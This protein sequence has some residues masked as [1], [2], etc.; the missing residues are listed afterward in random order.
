MT[1]PS[2]REFLQFWTFSPPLPAPTSAIRNSEQYPPHWPICHCVMSHFRLP[3]EQHTPF[4]GPVRD[5]GYGR[6]RGALT[7][8]QKIVSSRKFLGLTQEQ[9]A[10]KADIDV[11]TIRNA[12]SGKRLDLSTIQ[13]VAQC[14]LIPWQELL[15]ESL[16]FDAKTCKA[17]I[18]KWLR[19]WIHQDVQMIVDLY[20]PSARVMIAGAPTIPF[21]GEHLGRDAIQSTFELAWQWI[22]CSH[23]HRSKYSVFVANKQVLLSTFGLLESPNRASVTMTSLQHF[24]FQDQFISQHRIEY[25]TLAMHRLL[26]RG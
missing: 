15:Q 26:C 20:T 11:K 24:V 6:S 13:R 18:A 22:S 17:I 10:A 16:Q 25:D 1:F 12:E 2:P 19:A 14:L 7:N 4:T 8:G 9:L 3:N 5:S 21:A 23:R